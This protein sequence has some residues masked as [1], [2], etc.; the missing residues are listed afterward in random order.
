MRRRSGFAGTGVSFLPL[1]ESGESRRGRYEEHYL[2][3]WPEADA[4]GLKQCTEHSETCAVRVTYVN[5]GF[6]RQVLFDGGGPF[7]E[8]G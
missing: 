7:P 2:K 5:I 3:G 4:H 1:S 8:L 6:V